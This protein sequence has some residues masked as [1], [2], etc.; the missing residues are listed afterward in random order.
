MRHP[1]SRGRD[2]LHTGTGAEGAT[3]PETLRQKDRA[4]SNNLESGGL[5]AH[6]RRK[7]TPDGLASG[8][9]PNMAEPRAKLSGSWQMGCGP[10]SA[11]SAG[12]PCSS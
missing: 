7:P 9:Q 12:S 8:T 10:K 1:L 6:R 3:A 11:R 4:N 2:R 5:A